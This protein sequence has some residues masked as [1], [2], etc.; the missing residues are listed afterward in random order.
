VITSLYAGLLALVLFKLS[1]DS[2]NAR[3]THKISV[4]YG[5]NN[6]IAGVVSAHANFVAYVPLLLF[7]LWMAERSGLYPEYLIHVLG[8]AFTLGRVLHYLAFTGKKIDFKKRVLGMHLTLW[9]LLLLAALN[10]AL[11]VQQLALR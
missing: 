3:R 7:L 1:L 4:G 10:V 2:I 5:P 9:P 6:E 11:Y 8:L